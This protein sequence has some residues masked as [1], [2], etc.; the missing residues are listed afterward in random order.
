MGELVVGNE[1]VCGAKTNHTQSPHQQC[2]HT[3]RLRRLWQ[4]T[5][6]PSFRTVEVKDALP[7]GNF[8]YS[9][10]QGVQCDLYAVSVSTRP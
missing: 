8:S 4:K 7:S 3:F 1:T 5:Q 9:E 6:D 2:L 10:R